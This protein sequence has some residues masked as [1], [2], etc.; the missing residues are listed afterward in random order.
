MLSA[1]NIVL[2]AACMSANVWER[3]AANSFSEFDSEDMFACC[4]VQATPVMYA[5]HVDWLL[6]Q[7]IQ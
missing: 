2:L 4:E 7:V 1:D 3:Q 6:P 5:C